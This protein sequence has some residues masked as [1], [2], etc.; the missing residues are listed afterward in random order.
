M[1]MDG[2]NW[3]NVGSPLIHPVLC[4]KWVARHMT[5]FYLEVIFYRSHTRLNLLR[6]GNCS[7]I[8]I[9]SWENKISLFSISLVRMLIIIHL[10]ASNFTRYTWTKIILGFLN[11]IN[12]YQELCNNSFQ[13]QIKLAECATCFILE[14]NSQFKKNIGTRLFWTF[15]YGTLKQQDSL[16]L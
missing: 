9:Y 11:T 4:L 3:M 12:F 8:K 15:V 5:G 7:K 10:P 6:A 16:M 1:A 13:F 14:N 2:N